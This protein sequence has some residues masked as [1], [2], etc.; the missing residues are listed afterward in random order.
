MSYTTQQVSGNLRIQILIF[1]TP[2]SKFFSVECVSPLC[3]VVV[4]VDG[5]VLFFLFHYYPDH[6]LYSQTRTLLKVFFNC[7]FWTLPSQ[8]AYQS[9]SEWT[10]AILDWLF[11]I[12][13]HTHL[14]S[15][16]ILLYKHLKGYTKLNVC[17]TFFPIKKFDCIRFLENFDI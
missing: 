2:G 12:P 10:L 13:I 15:F 9:L 16:L 1:L 11:T 6:N 4:I 14:I 17:I 5:Q 3:D 7:L 8:N